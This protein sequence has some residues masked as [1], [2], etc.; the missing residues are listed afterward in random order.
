MTIGDSIIRVTIL[1]DVKK[2]NAA[3]GEA[4]KKVG[5]LIGSTAK[6][7]VGGFI[8][9]QAV[10]KAFDFLNTGLDNADK[11]GDALDRIAGAT[12]PEF[13]RRIEDIAFSMTDIGLSAPEVGDL[14]AK[15]T[16]L[17]TAAKVTEP[18]ILAI[19]PHMLELA[20]AIAATT[21]KPLDEVINDI[22]KAAQ[23]N[24][25]PVSEYGVVVDKA[26]NPDARLL[27]I[28]DQLNKKFPDAKS[29]A[30]DLAG[31]Q[32]ELAAKVD[33][34]ATKFGQMAEGPL[35]AVVDFFNHVLDDIPRTVKMFEDLG[36]SIVGFARTVLGP[37][38]NVRDLLE[39][40]THLAGG[41]SVK[42]P[43]GS[44]VP[45]FTEKSLVQ[46]QAAFD[47]RNGNGSRTKIGG[48]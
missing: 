43:V 20:S 4:D 34:L 33:N 44:T 45:R 31:A 9:L 6:V 29:A 38:G 47:D 46:A 21:G 26:L 35:T 41:G 25:K 40:I 8:G 39:D 48:P 5:G 42:A 23:G 36:G 13:A 19:T 24:Q 3:I 16:D 10:D 11:F 14:A 22:G 27:D 17:A 15:F 12:T 1:G 37:L 2:L 32:D 30:D 28:L 7:A 18:T